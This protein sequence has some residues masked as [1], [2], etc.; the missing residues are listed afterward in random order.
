MNFHR[1]PVKVENF[2]EVEP[3]QFTWKSRT[4]ARQTYRAH[5]VGVT[6]DIIDEMLQSETAANQL[7]EIIEAYCDYEPPAAIRRQVEVLLQY[8]PPNYLRGLK[9]IVLLNRGALGRD[10]RRKKIWSR[11]RKVRLAAANGSYSRATR[12]QPATVRLYVDNLLQVFPSWW[13][14]T[15]VIGYFPVMKVLY[16]EI[17]HHIHVVHR[18]EYEGKENVAE[19]WSLKLGRNFYRKR[20][21]YAWP[22]LLAAGKI[23]RLFRKSKKKVT[24]TR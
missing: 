15:P 6:Y 18:P 24:D 12:S 10:Q 5:W 7:P 22:L 23:I 13:T 16:H 19:K 9:R 21:W 8:V 14:H 11:N 17:G 2:C 3:N 20:F 4:Q 1:R